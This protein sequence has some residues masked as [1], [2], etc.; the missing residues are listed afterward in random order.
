MWVKR[1]STDFREQD[2]LS[3]ATGLTRQE[4]PMCR[5]GRCARVLPATAIVVPLD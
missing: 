1:E 2:V 5:V 4:V 3:A